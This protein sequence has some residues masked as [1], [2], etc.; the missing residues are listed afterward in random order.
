MA[1]CFQRPVG[2]IDASFRSRKALHS[3][4]L[5]HDLVLSS[6]ATA[7]RKVSIRS[8]AQAACID[9]LLVATLIRQLCSMRQK[10]V[11]IACPS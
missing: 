4:S 1:L 5:I 11:G 7:R 8:G 10:V 3:S 6:I 2:G 9:D